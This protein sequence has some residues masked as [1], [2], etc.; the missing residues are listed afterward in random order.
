MTET[1]EPNLTQGDNTEAFGQHLMK[2]NLRD[3]DH[4]L[5]NHSISKCEI[6]FACGVKKS[7]QNPQFPLI[8]DLTEDESDK[9]KVGNNTATIKIWDELGRPVTPKGSQVIVVGARKV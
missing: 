2:I 1:I 8:I 9:M 6:R 7:Y 3:P 5:D 4:L